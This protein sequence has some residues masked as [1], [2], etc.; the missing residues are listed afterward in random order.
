MKI[1]KSY[2]KQIIK[3]ELEAIKETSKSY[4][5][6]EPPQKV[7]PQQLGK[8]AEIAKAIKRLENKN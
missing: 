8:E 4:P 5:S 1:T 2:L 3:E 6:G 7:S